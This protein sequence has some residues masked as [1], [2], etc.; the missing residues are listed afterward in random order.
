MWTETGITVLVVNDGAAGRLAVNLALAP[1][2][3]RVLGA[4]E[5]G[6]VLAVAKSERPACVILDQELDLTG[7]RGSELLASLLGVDPD[8]AL[9]VLTASRNPVHIGAELPDSVVVHLHKPFAASDLSAAVG[10]ALEQRRQRQERAQVRRW[11]QDEIAERWASAAEGSRRLERLATASLEVLV[12]ALEAKDRFM[13]GHSLRVADLAAS[14]AAEL[15][16]PDDEIEVIRQAGRLHDIG[17]IGISDRIINK[18]GALTAA[19]VAEIRQHPILGDQ[20]LRKHP[21]LEPVARLVRSHHERW[22]G[23]GYPDGLAGEAIPLGGRILAA[24]EVY[25]ALVTDRVYRNSHMSPEEACR[26]LLRL[27]GS[28]LD[29]TVC[30]ALAKVVARRQ[31]LEFLVEADPARRERLEIRAGRHPAPNGRPTQRVE[32]G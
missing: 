10:R 4:P 28:A 11:L 25:D 18:E 13:V 29:P 9:V 8:M 22:D 5:S 32:V 15:G 12:T 14:V 24:S 3:Y 27:A 19:E 20:L 30:D 2:D 21:E 23:T 16:C 1:H 6:Q 7:L 26:Q 17:M 31:A